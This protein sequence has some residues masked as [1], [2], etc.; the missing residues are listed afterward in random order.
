MSSSAPPE[1]EPAADV[2]N[3]RRV[4]LLREVMVAQG[5]AETP[6]YITETGWNDHPRWT[7]AVR[8]GQRIT[9]TLDAIR[10]AEANWP[11]VEMVAIWAFRFPAPTKS[12]MDYYT[13][14]TPEFVRRPIY[15][16]LRDYATK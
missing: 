13:L 1:A 6:V 14:V 8:P 12:Y 5:D 15:D 7:R 9:Y 10:F 2:L 3:F 11:Y 16:A 4:E